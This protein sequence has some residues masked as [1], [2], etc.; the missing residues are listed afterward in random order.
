MATQNRTTKPQPTQGSAAARQAAQAPAADAAKM[1]KQAADKAEL[2][3]QAQAKQDEAR[4]AVV[5]ETA[6]EGSVATTDAAAA[7]EGSL[8][9]VSGEAAVAEAGTAGAAGTAAP[10]NPL[11]IGAGVVGVVA[12][13]AAAGGSSSGGSSSQPIAQNNTQQAAQNQGSQKPATP[14]VEQ[15]A[16]DTKPA[17][18]T[19]PA[20]DAKPA[21]P[22]KPAEQPKVDPTP[23]EDLSKPATAGGTAEAPKVAADGVTNLTNFADLFK[24]AGANGG[25][26]EFIKISRILSAE[27]AKDAQARAVDSDNSR[28]YEV[29]DAGRPI[30]LAEAEAM[31]KQLGGKLMSVDSA[32][33]KAWLDKNLFGALGEYDGDKSLAEAAA[34]SD[35]DKAAQQKVLDG[36]LASNGAWLGKNATDGADAKANAVIRNGNNAE[37]DGAMKLYEAAGTTLSKFVIEYEGYKSPLLLDGKPVVEGQIINKADAAK[38]A[39]NADLNKGGQITYQAVDSNDAAT[40]KPVAD[41][42]AG[43]MTLSES[44]EVKHPMTVPTNPSAQDQPAQGGAAGKPGN[45]VPQ[46]GQNGQDNQNSNQQPAK[47]ELPATNQ[48]TAEAPQVATTGE[49]KLANIASAFEKSA[50]EGKNVEFIKIAKIDTSEGEAGARIF[51]EVETTVKAPDAADPVKTVSTTAYEVISTKEPITRAQ[52]E[53]MAKARGGKLL[54]I[55]SAEEAKF[56]GGKLFGSLGEYDSDESVAEVQGDSAK[57]A[58]Q[59]VLNGQLAKNGAWLGNDS[60]AG[61]VNN[62]DAIIRNG[63]GTDLPKG[64]K[65]YDFSGDKLSRFVI[66]IEN[67]KAPMTLNGKP[68]VDGQIIEKADF[69][70]LVWN[71]DHNMG[72]KITYVAVQSG[73]ANAANVEGAEQKTLTVTESPAVTHPTAPASAPA[74]NPQQGGAG[75]PEAQN[76]NGQAGGSKPQE[77]GSDSKAGGTTQNAGSQSQG[78][79][80]PS[81][82]AGSD[83]QP[84]SAGGQSSDAPSKPAGTPEGQTSGTPLQSGGQADSPAPVKAAPSYEPNKS[85]SVAHDANDAK[86][87]KEVFEGTNSANKPEA[88]KATG[89]AAGA[90]KVDGNVITNGALIKAA[91][92]DKVTWDASK[93]EGGTFKFTPVQA[94]GDALAKGGDEQTITI[95]EASAPVQA[96]PAPTYD[97]N[98]TVDVAHDATDAKIAKEVF[99]G[100]N[101][102][103]K[104]EAVK[105]TGFAA[106]TLKVNGQAINPGDK[107]AAEN[108]DKVTWDASKGEGGSFKFTPVQANGDALAQGGAEQTITINEA[109]APAP[110]KAAYVGHDVTKADI[111]PQVFQD[112]EGSSPAAVKISGLTPDT[113]KKGGVSV[114]EG[115]LITSRDFDKLTWDSTKGDGGSF[116]FTPVQANGDAIEGATEKT[117]DVKEVAEPKTVEVGRDA[118]PLT[119]DKSIFGDADAVQILTVRGPVTEDRTDA[120][121]LTYTPEGGQKTSLID[122]SYLDKANFDKVQWDARADENNA[123]T[124]RI[125]FKPVTAAHEEIPG[126][127]PKEIKV[128]EATGELDYSTSPKT[129]HVETHDGTKMIP[130]AVFKGTGAPPLY[131]WIKDSTENEPT[132]S[133]RSFLKLEGGADSG[134]DVGHDAVIS[135]G[136]MNKVQWDATYNNGGTIRFR[137]LDGDKKEIGE[138][139]TITV[140]ESPSNEVQALGAADVLNPQGAGAHLKS[141]A[142][143][144]PAEPSSNLLDDLHNQITPLI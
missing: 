116:K 7:A 43:T 54:S 98:K 85:V 120:N 59:D 71:S 81:K 39:W 142:A 15:P 118:A 17:E 112:S 102:A 50:G 41:A 84:G 48:G 114:R 135:I 124:Y 40:A 86:I 82:P 65:A 119:L 92:F 23:V 74:A 90:L 63:N 94:N 12:L 47:P 125:L 129:V 67:Y 130:E 30:T 64:Y 26:A 49:T 78:Q 61:A 51:R 88:V 111:A 53:E 103:N 96:K 29:I 66:E 122:E 89:F 97:A 121:V 37:G 87:A 25:E 14:A 80:P 24:T 46:A 141:M 127:E 9:A 100:T 136:E 4:K 60:T 131:V 28:A 21:E 5:A 134:K 32:A 101:P 109:P 137:P 68:V 3:K 70:K 143:Y 1:A 126:A 105:A 76:N 107:I 110:K 2:D 13:A 144:T 10:I 57:A 62:A 6:A 91:D 83:T 138:W 18:A 108:F 45:D 77:G 106:G 140:T 35:S 52:A 133:D 44:A 113:L 19:Q 33:E 36:Q 73:E 104:P 75:T 99:E 117:V 72:G 115:D 55:D 20:Q 16:Q 11:A 132:G 139:Q 58:Q 123:G 34:K 27:N 79:T 69:D 42:K 93:G 95:N 128:H 8:G 31:A 56:I 38:L 22:A